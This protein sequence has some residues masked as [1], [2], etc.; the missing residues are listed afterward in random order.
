MSGQQ[1]APSAA[2]MNILQLLDVACTL[3]SDIS[4]TVSARLRVLMAELSDE[5]EDEDVLLRDRVIIELL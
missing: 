5:A 3:A 1:D 4:P 2:P